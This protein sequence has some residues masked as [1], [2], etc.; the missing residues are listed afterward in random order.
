M[1][2]WLCNIYLRY[3]WALDPPVKGSYYSSFYLSRSQA[4]G[5]RDWLGDLEAPHLK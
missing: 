5:V 4:G 1:K 2:F 3:L